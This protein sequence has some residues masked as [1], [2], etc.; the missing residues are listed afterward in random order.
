[1]NRAALGAG[2]RLTVTLEI[3]HSVIPGGFVRACARREHPP[4]SGEPLSCDHY[5]RLSRSASSS[6]L[7]SHPRRPLIPPRDIPSECLFVFSRHRL[8]F[9]ASLCRKQFII[10][11]I[12]SIDASIVIYAPRTN[13]PITR[14]RSSSSTC[15]RFF[16]LVRAIKRS[17]NHR[18]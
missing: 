4:S 16:S 3:R 5:F 6:V 18:S 15:A 13:Q 14:I 8:S 2:H 11:V 10:L 12:L 9:H 17:V 1:M 7:T